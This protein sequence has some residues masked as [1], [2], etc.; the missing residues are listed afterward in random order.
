MDRFDTMRAFL[1][2]AEH[3][4]FAEAARRL[5]WSPA[6]VTRAVAQLEDEL[7]VT[8][9]H[10][11]TRSVKLTVRGSIFLD[12]ARQLLEDLEDAHR[13]V[14]GDDAR[15]SG[16][17]T[18]AAPIMFGKLH[19]LPIVERLLHEFPD[20]SVQLSLSDRVVHLA[21]DGVD[22]AVRIGALGDSALK[23]LKVGEVRRVTVASPSYLAGR[24]PIEAPPDLSVHDIIA[25]GGLDATDEWKFGGAT[26]SSV[27]ITPRLR[28]NTADAAISAC[29]DGLGIT[30]VLSYQVIA[31][32]SQG[33]LALILED[34]AP[35]PIPV[36]IIFPARRVGS[37]NVS[38]FVKMAREHFRTRVIN[39]A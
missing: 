20:L 8:L 13:R 21:E 22:V 3:E 2:V 23:A 17:L 33:A 32:I 35:P 1:H 19:V 12:R 27:R 25:F 30:R 34:A 18:V 9:L 11:T 39:V 38:T 10:R 28:V 29:I 7:G 26:R 37:P 14:R 36:N 31:P 6:T 24:P 5:R 16:Q 15:P 4:S